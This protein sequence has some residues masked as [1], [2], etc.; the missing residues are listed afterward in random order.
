MIYHIYCYML[1]WD[2][3]A[4]SFYSCIFDVLIFFIWYFSNREIFPYVFAWICFSMWKIIFRDF[5]WFFK[6]NKQFFCYRLPGWYC[7]FHSIVDGH[8]SR[9]LAM[10]LISQNFCIIYTLYTQLPTGM[11]WTGKK[12][13]V[14]LLDDWKYVILAEYLWQERRND[15]R[16][17]SVMFPQRA[18]FLGFW[19][20]KFIDLILVERNN[21]CTY[22]FYS[23]TT[24]IC[25]Y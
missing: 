5:F 2:G 3:L 20:G 19:T 17:K 25:N 12:T 9:Y 6:F 18:L 24:Y 16:A 7:I 10:A 11:P 22:I 1:V 14:S 8:L 4:F 15:K 13:Y 23:V 21:L